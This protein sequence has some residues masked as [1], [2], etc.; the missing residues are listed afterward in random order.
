MAEVKHDV[1][2]L[3]WYD[4]ESLMRARN[5]TEARTQGQMLYGWDAINP[6]SCKARLAK[7][8]DVERIVKRGGSILHW[9]R[10]YNLT[11]CAAPALR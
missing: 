9:P 10:L 4:H 6:K 7:P 11:C 8:E 5:I 3:K 1:Y 2:L